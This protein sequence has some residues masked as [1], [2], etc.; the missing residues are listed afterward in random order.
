M[1]CPNCKIPC[2]GE[3]IDGVK[4]LNCPD[5]GWFV[6]GDEGDW[7]SCDEP[8]RPEKISGPAKP[9]S[10]EPGQCA[11]AQAAPVSPDKDEQ[12]END[13][14]GIFEFTDRYE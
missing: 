2:E 5:C 12:D 4:Y 10:S 9:E 14:S 1:N 7:T 11:A 8:R 3:I 13:G 6:K